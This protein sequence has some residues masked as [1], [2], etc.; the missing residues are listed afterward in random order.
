MSQDFQKTALKSET[1][2]IF[3]LEDDESLGEILSERLTKEG[4]FVKWCKTL[5]DAVF[6]FET[7]SVWDLALLDVGLPDG[8][9]FQFADLMMQIQKNKKF[10]SLTPFLFLTAQADAESRLRGYELGAHEYIPKPFHLKELLLRISRVLQS[11]IQSELIETEQC[12]LHVQE[13]KVTQKKTLLQT[14]LT[15][16]EM[17]LLVLLIKSAPQLVHRDQVMDELWG[18]NKEINQRSIDNMIVKLRQALGDEGRNLKTV[19][20]HGYQ[21]MRESLS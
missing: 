21:F 4:F 2:K 14:S 15:A 10:K 1:K 8:D 6:F 7:D 13:L 17:K 3:L 12:L 9:G 5:K 16:N 20:G 11:Y 18:E 19:R